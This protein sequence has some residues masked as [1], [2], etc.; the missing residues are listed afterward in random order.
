MKI[1]NI[2]LLTSVL[3]FTLS[4]FRNYHFSPLEEIIERVIPFAKESKGIYVA[5]KVYDENDSK[6][7]LDNELISRGYLPIQFMIQ[8]NT[9][10]TY[11]VSLDSLS[12]PAEEG[13]SAALAVTLSDSLPRSIIFRIAGFL[14]FPF[15]I[16]GIIDGIVTL[17]TYHELKLD[18]IAKSLKEEGE[19][20]LPYSTVHRIAFVKEDNFR[21]NFTFSLDQYDCDVDFIEEISF[22]SPAMG[23]LE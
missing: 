5:Y 2:I 16:P 8:N 18:Y 19:Y 13:S 20:I 6:K 17:N 14:F 22:D 1:K 23:A 10:L 7:F 9:R 11:K 21:E 3:F 12:L 4:S 15:M